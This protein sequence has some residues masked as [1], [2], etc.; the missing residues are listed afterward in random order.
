MRPRSSESVLITF[1][2]YTARLSPRISLLIRSPISQYNI[3]I[4]AFT[5]TATRMRA[6]SMRVRRSPS[7]AG[8]TK[9]DSSLCASQDMLHRSFLSGF[10][11]FFSCGPLHRN[12]SVLVSFTPVPGLSTHSV[13]HCSSLSSNE[14]RNL[15]H[16]D[17][18]MIFACPIQ[19]GYLSG[20][21]GIPVLWYVVRCN[22]LKDRVF[23]GYAL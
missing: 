6:D 18:F 4:S 1:F 2:P 22:C 19:A 8:G 17:L 21:L 15:Q 10:P 13:D 11:P 14:S 20:D 5:P 23:T 3:T 16:H 12:T 7:N 9:G